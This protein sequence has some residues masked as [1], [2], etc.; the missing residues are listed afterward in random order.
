[1]TTRQAINKLFQI[2]PILLPGITKLLGKGE[3]R[4]VLNVTVVKISVL[5]HTRYF[6]KQT[7]KW[8]DKINC[9]LEAYL[10]QCLHSK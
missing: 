4:D 9:K 5:C 1:M 6:L 8:Q 2:N 7:G 10:C 3:N